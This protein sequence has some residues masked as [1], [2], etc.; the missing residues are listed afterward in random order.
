MS[1]LNMKNKIIKTYTDNFFMEKFKIDTTKIENSIV[2]D[3][4]AN[5]ITQYLN[6]NLQPNQEEI[7]TLYDTIYNDL[8]DF[9][10]D[11]LLD[12]IKIEEN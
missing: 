3:F 1:E 6:F 12:I 9:Y 10:L 4:A 2:Y 11:K 7:N 5:N 8:N